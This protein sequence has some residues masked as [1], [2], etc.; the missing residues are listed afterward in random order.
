MGFQ[1]LG[2]W[3]LGGFGF[4][5][6]LRTKRIRFDISSFAEVFVVDVFSR[7]SLQCLCIIGSVE[8][9]CD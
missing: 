4:T 2:V 7:L 5:V 6:G 1:G 8:G 9:F 3:G